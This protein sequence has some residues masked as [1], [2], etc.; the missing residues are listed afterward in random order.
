MDEEVKYRLVSDFGYGDKSWVE[1]DLTESQALKELVSRG[2][3]DPDITIDRALELKELD[4]WYYLEID[5][6]GEEDWDWMDS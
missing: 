1:R 4:Y 6:G 2:Y 5:D 3:C